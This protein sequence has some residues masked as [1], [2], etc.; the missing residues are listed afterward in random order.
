MN[1][2]YL[3]G[4]E[5]ITGGS[6]RLRASVR[7]HVVLVRILYAACTKAHSKGKCRDAVAGNVTTQIKFC[8]WDSLDRPSATLVFT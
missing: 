5:L 8:R 4:W 3:G 1:A 7:S 2:F 6:V